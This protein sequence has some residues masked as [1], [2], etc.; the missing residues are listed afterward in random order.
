[1]NIGAIIKLNRINQNLTQEDLA[2]GIISISYLSK[3]ENGKIEPNEEVIKLLCRKLGIQV[4]NQIDDSIREK[5]EEWFRLLLTSSDVDELSNKFEEIKGLSKSLHNSELQILIKIHMI[6]HYL[7]INDTDQAFE[8]INS[9]KDVSG[10]FNNLQKYY[11]FKFNGNYYSILEE[12]ND[13]LH[14]YTLAEDLIPNIELPEQEVADLQYALSVTYSKFRLTSEAQS[15]AN[16]ALEYYRQIYHFSRCAECHLIL[17]ICYRRINNHDKA[18]KNYNLAK[19]LAES[20]QN[21][22]LIRLTHLNMGYLYLVKGDPKLAIEQFDMI[23]NEEDST[24][25]DRLLAITSIIGQSYNSKN[26][27][28]AKKRIK[29][30]LSWI[31]S[32]NKNKYLSFYYEILS[33]LYLIDKENEK[34]ENLMVNQFIPYLKEQKNYAKLTEYA[35]MLGEYFESMHK[36]K[37]AA[38]Y[39]KLVNYSYKQII[40]V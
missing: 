22:K 32:K 5:C 15:Y 27:D 7:K 30:A 31:N 33:Y 17:G 38:N 9:L 23:V 36:Y 14:N 21:K 40:Q 12:E 35:E 11:W 3:I 2:D 20:T 18:L 4:N 16:K 28:E 37:N 24:L 34:F 13:A 1:M 19:Q 6:R 25:H 10:T 39:Y 29:S 8:K 26:F